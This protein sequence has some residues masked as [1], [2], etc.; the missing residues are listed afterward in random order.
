M[1]RTANISLALYY[2][3]KHNNRSS[4]DIANNNDKVALINDNCIN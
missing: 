2:V 1:F 3:G 4:C